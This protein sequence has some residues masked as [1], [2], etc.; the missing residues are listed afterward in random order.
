MSVTPY[1]KNWHK[2]KEANGQH[3]H[4]HENHK[5]QIQYSKFHVFHS[6]S[7]YWLCITLLTAF[8]LDLHNVKVGPYLE[9]FCSSY[10]TAILFTALYYFLLCFPADIHV[11]INPI[12]AA[13]KLQSYGH[14][15]QGL[16]SS[17]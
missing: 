6:I 4:H 11:T 9:L 5:F 3:L 16:E 14:N 12:K 10:D 2:N 7:L 15:C 1:K 8:H 17:V 13:V